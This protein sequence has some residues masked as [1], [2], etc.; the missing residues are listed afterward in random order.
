MDQEFAQI[1][2]NFEKYAQDKIAI[3]IFKFTHGP[4]WTVIL[5]KKTDGIEL[6]VTGKSL[7]LIDAMS[8]AETKWNRATGHGIKEFTGKLLEGN[9]APINGR[10]LD[11]DIPF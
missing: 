6:K 4:E 7:L 3:S 9:A 11:D 10:D 1:L 2:S 8:D 5:E